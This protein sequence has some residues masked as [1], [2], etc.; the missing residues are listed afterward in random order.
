METRAGGRGIER[1]A[2]WAFHRD[3]LLDLFVGLLLA[4][5]AL[6]RPDHLWWVWNPAGLAFIVGGPI[7]KRRITEPRVGFFTPREATRDRDTLRMGCLVPVGLVVEVALIGLLVGMKAGRF[8]ALA[9]CFPL[10]V[11]G[12]LAALLAA[13]A[14]LLRLNRF[15]AYAGLVLA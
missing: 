11:G 10:L 15:L 6:V 1:R 3:G 4:F 8:P 7:L 5:S 12:A 13:L 2:F 9:P 14:G